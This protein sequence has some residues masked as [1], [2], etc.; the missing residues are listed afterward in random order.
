MYTEFLS[1]PDNFVWGVATASYQIEGGAD[2]DG[3]GKSIWDVFSHVKGATA[4]GENGD[5]ACDHYHRYGEDVQ[6]MRSLGIKNY[7]LSMAWPRIFPE[8]AGHLNQH[9]LDF[10]DRLFDA[11]LAAGITPWVTLFH[12]DLP[13]ALQKNGGFASRDC[14]D[15]FCEYANTVTR[16]FG[17]RIKNWIT[18]NEPWVYSIC[19]HLYGVH[20]PGIQNLATALSAAHNIL[21]AHGKSL[22][23]IRSNA[24]GA[25]AGIVNNLA[26]IESASSR[27]EDIDAAK[28]WD[29]AF[30]RWFMD[31]LSGKGYPQEIAA[32]Y[33][34][35]MPEI[36]DGDF[37]HISGPVDFLGINYYTRRLVSAAPADGHINAKQTYRA[38]IKRAEFEEWEWYPE[39][40]YKTLIDIKEQYN[41]I[42][43]YITENGTSGPDVIS[44]DG[45]VH[46]PERVEYLRRHF[47]AAWQAIQEGCDV[48][49]YFVWTLYD[50]FEWGFG[51]TKQFGLVYID[52]QN[53]LRRVIK[54]SGHFTAGVFDRNGF[55]VD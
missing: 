45:C 30:N 16:H 28:R 26:W 4:D 10:Y 32:W 9:G 27:Q 22:P 53:G 54:D 19:G 47:A 52:R 42:P 14:A 37:D 34:K 5:T 51:F 21:L 24:R 44:A 33:G 39:G 15:R 17:D 6:L 35:N 3:K 46:D 12:W 8:G 23:V 40:L 20:A 18:F 7:R 48:R 41:N 25:K 1:F 31:P 50:N 2:E 36:K 29:L 43:V 49:G 55:T 11:C 38:H 13:L